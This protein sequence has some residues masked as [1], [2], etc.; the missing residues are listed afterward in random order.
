MPQDEAEAVRWYTRAADQGL[1][2]AQFD[3]AYMYENGKGVMNDCERAVRLYEV[4]A[5]SVPTARHNLAVIYAQGSGPVRKDPII[6]YKWAVLSFA[7][8]RFA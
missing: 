4:A 8:K 2:I 7:V 1:P 3:L 5:L 6:A